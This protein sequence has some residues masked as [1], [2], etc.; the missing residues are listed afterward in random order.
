MAGTASHPPGARE[1][2]RFDRTLLA[3][4]GQG[5]QDRATLRP[6]VSFHR[7][8][9]EDLGHVGDLVALVS[10]PQDQVMLPVAAGD[11]PDAAGRLHQLPAHRHGPA[12]IGP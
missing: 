8:V 1:R 12:D 5:G 11:R 2:S 9:A 6:G 3:P 4:S 10:H 7:T